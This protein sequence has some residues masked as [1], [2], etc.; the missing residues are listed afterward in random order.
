LPSI[1][2]TILGKAP[3]KGNYRWKNDEAGRRRWKRIKDFEELVAQLAMAKGAQRLRKGFRDEDVRVL[4]TCYN[5]D[6]DSDGIG[7]GVWD[8]L[9]GVCY[10]NDKHID[11]PNKP[12]V[13]NKGARVTV[14]V[15]WRKK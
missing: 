9:E 3:S 6:G 12:V 13:D 7:K 15:T 1:R 10:E 5:Q 11:K 14:T 4:V 8:A 2:F